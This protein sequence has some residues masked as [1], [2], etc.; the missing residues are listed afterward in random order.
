MCLDTS[1]TAFP[2]ICI[3]TRGVA[4]GG[5]CP[6]AIKGKITLARCQYADGS[7]CSL[8]SAVLHRPLMSP[9]RSSIW[10]EGC[11]HATHESQGPLSPAMKAGPKVC[12]APDTQLRSLRV[13]SS[14]LFRSQAEKKM[15]RTITFKNNNNTNTNNSNQYCC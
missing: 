13:L 2:A 12:S 5:W 15:T 7:S 1:Q 14:S 10:L 4:Q 6:C 11:A 3:V 9:L 8:Q